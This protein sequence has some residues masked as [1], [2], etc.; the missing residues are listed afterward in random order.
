MPRWE[1]LWGKSP[2]TKQE[3]P[4]V[5]PEI[6]PGFVP[7]PELERVIAAARD[8]QLRAYGEA[9]DGT[10]ERADRLYEEERALLETHRAELLAYLE[11][12]RAYTERYHA[13][14]STNTEVHM[15]PHGL[16]REE[17]SRFF[18][19]SDLLRKD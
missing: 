18:I 14:S 1:R 5:Q 11:P 16:S 12:Y 17:H 4:V 6:V 10:R 8:L 19:L 13:E 15:H 7:D 9:R 3:K 2:E